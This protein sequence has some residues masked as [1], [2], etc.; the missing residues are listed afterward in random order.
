MSTPIPLC[1]IF[2]A[3]FFQSGCSVVKSF[4]SFSPDCTF[5]SS[6]KKSLPGPH[7]GS[8]DNEQTILP[9]VAERAA[10]AAFM[11]GKSAGSGYFISTNKLGSC[12]SSV[13]IRSLNKRSQKRTADGKHFF[14]R[15]LG[16]LKLHTW[17][18][19]DLRINLRSMVQTDPRYRAQPSSV[20]FLLRAVA[21]SISNG[22]Q[23]VERT[24]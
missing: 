13:V 22:A 19:R 6:L 8:A 4:F 17:I 16:I 12:V 15:A 14:F 11:A 5:P 18:H 7:V 21:I 9:P 1:A 3:V 10:S 23:A 20:P 2:S 24:R